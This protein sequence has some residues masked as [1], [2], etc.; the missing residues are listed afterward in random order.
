M[1]LNVPCNIMKL[2]LVIVYSFSHAH[3]GRILKQEQ[4]INN[5]RTDRVT[6][7]FLLKSTHKS[8]RQISDNQHLQ[9]YFI[10]FEMLT[11]SNDS[12]SGLLGL[13]CI[14]TT[15]VTDDRFY[16]DL[17]VGNAQFLRFSFL[18]VICTLDR[19]QLQGNFQSLL[20][21]FV[22][23]HSYILRR[24]YICNTHNSNKMAP[25]E[26]QP[27]GAAFFSLCSLSQI[28]AIFTS[29]TTHCASSLTQPCPSPCSLLSSLL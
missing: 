29:H 13:S 25:N 26:V 14:S 28:L 7:N 10:C 19:H 9:L 1:T 12:Q 23:L 20:F 2:P 8:C 21:N 17:I 4:H 5:T 15:T 24:L 18:A 11:L 16:S 22:V 27:Y 3:T 6:Y